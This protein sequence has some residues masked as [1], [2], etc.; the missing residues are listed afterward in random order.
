[1][2]SRKRSFGEVLFD[3]DYLSDSEICGPLTQDFFQLTQYFL[4]LPS[5]VG[6]GM[7]V[8]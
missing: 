3:D 4:D 5:Q 8:I 7:E 2:A 6:C 1:M